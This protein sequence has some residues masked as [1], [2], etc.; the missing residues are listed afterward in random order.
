M[1]EKKQ[2]TNANN[3]PNPMG[4]F[5]MFGPGMGYGMPATPPDNKNGGKKKSKRKPKKKKPAGQNAGRERRNSV[6]VRITL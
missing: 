4:G 2:T 5:P 1:A 6:T 3:V